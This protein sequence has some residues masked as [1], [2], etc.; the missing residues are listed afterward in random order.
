MNYV[1]S[2]LVIEIKAKLVKSYEISNFGIFNLDEWTI[3]M[4]C[5]HSICEFVFRLL[6]LIMIYTMYNFLEFQ[7]NGSNE[8]DLPNLWNRYD[9]DLSSLWNCWN[10]KKLCQQDGIGVMLFLSAKF[11][12]IAS[13]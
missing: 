4:I 9:L 12:I 8:L 5:L 2:S 13:N 10:F 1:V 3:H 7:S 6:S 11:L